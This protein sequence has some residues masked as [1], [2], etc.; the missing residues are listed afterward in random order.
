MN[1]GSR[2]QIMESGTLRQ[3]CVDPCSKGGRSCLVPNRLPPPCF[4]CWPVGHVRLARE[5]DHGDRQCA[6]VFR[7]GKRQH[8]YARLDLLLR[9][10]RA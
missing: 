4:A 2:A 6:D 3:R 1:N 5:I 7:H 8:S 9:H 10:A